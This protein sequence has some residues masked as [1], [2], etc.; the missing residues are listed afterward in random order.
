MEV[1]A[2]HCVLTEHNGG[3][4]SATQGGYG[5]G[6]AALRICERRLDHL[7]ML[8]DDSSQEEMP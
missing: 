5:L 7:P 6:Q 1:G 2:A 3:L 8:T 4:D